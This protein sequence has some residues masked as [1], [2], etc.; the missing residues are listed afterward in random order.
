M[1][2]EQQN[3]YKEILMF[4]D[5]V[6]SMN[7]P[8]ILQ[9]Y[10]DDATQSMSTLDIKKMSEKTKES[11]EDPDTFLSENKEFLESYLAYIHQ[12]NIK[13]HQWLKMK[14]C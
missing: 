3:A 10:L 11:I 2:E 5:N 13:T 1:T 9:T 6:P 4:L 8:E 7:F 12:R 14:A